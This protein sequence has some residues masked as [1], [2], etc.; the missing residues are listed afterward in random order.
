VI[1]CKAFFIR[2][3]EDGQY[4]PRATGALIF[5]SFRG[6][7]PLS[8]VQRLLTEIALSGEEGGGQWFLTWGKFSPRGN[9]HLPRGKC[10]ES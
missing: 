7:P 10:T 6:M 5:A 2:F 4:K 1:S 8:F 9:F 3:C